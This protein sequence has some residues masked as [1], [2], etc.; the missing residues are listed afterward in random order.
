MAFSAAESAD[1]GEGD[2]AA[3]DIEHGGERSGV[4][5]VSGSAMPAVMRPMAQVSSFAAAPHAAAIY[6]KTAATATSASFFD[7]RMRSPP[8]YCYDGDWENISVPREQNVI[9]CKLGINIQAGG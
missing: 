9:D 7:V 6:I 2:G 5:A 4:S 3:E 8:H 1:A